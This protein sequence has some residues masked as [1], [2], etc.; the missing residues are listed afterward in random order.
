MNRPN[1]PGAVYRLEAARALLAK[2]VTFVKQAKDDLEEVRYVI[3][4][5]LDCQNILLSLNHTRTEL[6]KLGERDSGLRLRSETP[7]EG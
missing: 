6:T 7:E 4:P 3:E 1:S 2:A 5:L